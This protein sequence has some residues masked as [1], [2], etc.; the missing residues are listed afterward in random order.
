[1]P[2]KGEAP[3]WCIVMFDLPVG[4]KRQRKEASRFRNQLLDLGFARAQLSV[5]AQYL[6][7]ASGVSRLAK[8]IKK[9]LPHGGDVRILSVSDVQWSKMIRFSNAEEAKA[10]ETPSQLTIF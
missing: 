6:P 10:E 3:V 2:R 5:Y 4:S 8:T 1:M 7:L 9:E